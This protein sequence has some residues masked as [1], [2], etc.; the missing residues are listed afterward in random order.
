MT[1]DIRTAVRSVLKNEPRI[2]SAEL[3]D[4]SVTDDGALIVEGEFATVRAKKLALERIG[5]IPGVDVIIDRIRV[6]PA[7][8]MSD[9]DI[10]IHLRHAFQQE[11]SFSGLE[12]SELTNGKRE[13]I[14]SPPDPVGSLEYAVQ[15][16]T[17]TLNGDAPGFATK[18]LAGVLAWWI[19]G[20][21]DVI[22]GIAEPDPD[23]D[24]PQSIEEAVRIAL[25]KDPF[26]TAGQIRVGVR[27]RVVR[28]TGLVA[29]DT[30][31]DMAENDAWY[32][33]G[34]NDVIN[35]LEVAD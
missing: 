24:S 23:Q 12:I 11:P 6:R 31:R 15:D 27:L 30:E 7:E 4:I 19:P 28:L 9:A 14:S 25:E 21:R 17:V 33:F 3:V 16:G 35:E 18:R 8:S 26:V 34:V 13:P 32:V 5:G 2:G 1:R 20:S 29:S 22:N 10:R